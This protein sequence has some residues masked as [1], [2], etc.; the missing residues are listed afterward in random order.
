MKTVLVTGGSKG[1]GAAI[2]RRYRQG[3]WRVLA[4]RSGELDLSQASSIRAWLQR[5][6][7]EGIDALVNNAGINHVR[8]LDGLESGDWERMLQVNLTAPFELIKAL[9]G[10]MV[11]KGW[12]R[13][14][15]IGSAYS[16]VS[17]PGR[18]GYAAAKSGLLGLTRTAA[19][20]LGGSGVLAN[21]VS[22]G[23][24]ETD[25]T[26]LNNTPDQLERLRLQVPVG[27]LGTPDEVAELV[28]F[29]GSEI[30]TYINGAAIPIDG[31]FL[32]Q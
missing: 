10:P 27:R 30:N 7:V 18:A 29:L 32:C 15:N 23:F 12:G 25:M 8:E 3:G 4:P 6:E 28:F 22:P 19:L 5:P 21:L 24:I 16:F 20:E 26:R 31:G 2:C 1:I 11:R 13:I 9:S 14:V 17:R